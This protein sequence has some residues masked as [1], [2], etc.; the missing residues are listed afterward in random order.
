MDLLRGQL[1]S[2]IKVIH[3]DEDT[4]V[5]ETLELEHGVSQVKYPNVNPIRIIDTLPHKSRDCYWC[6]C[7]RHNT[8]I[9]QGINNGTYDYSVEKKPE[10]MFVECPLTLEA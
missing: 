8:L 10:K 3:E 7:L 1:I 6:W 9:N 5:V 4:H 2:I